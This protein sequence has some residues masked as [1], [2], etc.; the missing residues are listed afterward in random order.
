MAVMPVVDVIAALP[1]SIS[2]LGVRERT[3][4]F[5]LGQLTGIA[6]S[7]AV[8]A[9][10]IGF[11]FNIFWGLVGGLAI[12][13]ARQ[14]KAMSATIDATPA[15][16][17]I[18]LAL[19]SAFLGVYA[20]G[21]FLCGLNEAGIHPGH[22]SGSSAGAIA[23]GFYA[24]GLRGEKLR[25]GRSFRRAEALL[26]G[27]RDDSPGR[28]NVFHRETHRT[29]ER[30]ARDP[31]PEAGAAECDLIEDTAFA[32]LSIAVTDLR[33]MEAK[34][35]ASGPLAESIMASCS[36]PILF[37]GQTIAGTKFH[38]G[39]I[40]H[41]LPIDPFVSDPSIHTIIVHAVSN[42]TKQPRKHLGVSN[43]FSNSHEMLNRE[44]TAHRTK[45][46]QKNGKRVI[47]VETNHPHPGVLQSAATKRRF[48]DQGQATGLSLAGQLPS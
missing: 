26:S 35:L 30:K 7:A 4:E 15:D 16:P 31:P 48:F 44:L 36:V 20:H 23:G 45:E 9:S 14:Q 13:T 24:A 25:G 37:T 10:L 38:D 47:F 17:G 34:F 12:I 1:I 40:L 29:D 5:M 32:K 18:A 42:S 21:G 3:F 11:L 27:C 2:G 28:A 46:A 39:G 8:S 43:A 22:I 41:E 6:P 33:K 19:G